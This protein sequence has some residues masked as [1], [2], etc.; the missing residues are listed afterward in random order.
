M[1]GHASASFAHGLAWHGDFD[2]AHGHN[3]QLA[4]FFWR[5]AA[6][7]E[8]LVSGQR[9]TDFSPHSRQF[10]ALAC[11]EEFLGELLARDFVIGGFGGH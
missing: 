10:G 2:G 11:A 6:F 1:R 5:W 7:R 4:R 9:R 8:F 3:G